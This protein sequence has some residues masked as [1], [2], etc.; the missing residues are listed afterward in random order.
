[1]KDFHGIDLE[2]LFDNQSNY[3]EEYRQGELRDEDI[4]RAEKAL[5]YKLPESYIQLLRLQNGGIINDDEYDEAWLEAIYGIGQEPGAYNGLEDMDDNWKNEWEYPDIGIPF[6]QTQSAGHDMY[7]MDMRSVNAQ[8]E[9][10]IVRIDNEMD[11]KIFF[12]ADD[13]VSFL[14]LVV[15]NEEIEETEIT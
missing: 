15:S 7:Y 2:L 10:R 9:P 6:G 12:V 11:N 13:L 4:A 5:G 1:M 3:G 8:G 14:K